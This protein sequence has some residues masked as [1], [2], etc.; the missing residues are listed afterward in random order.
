MKAKNG[1]SGFVQEHRTFLLKENE[2]RVSK[3]NKRVQQITSK[4]WNNRR[5]FIFGS[6]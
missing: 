4:R 2:D 1:P 3:M 5:I 6:Y